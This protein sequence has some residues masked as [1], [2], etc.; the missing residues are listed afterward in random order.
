M[1]NPVVF[2]AGVWVRCEPELSPEADRVGVDSQGSD[3]PVAGDGFS[4]DSFH[5]SSADVSLTVKR[6]DDNVTDVIPTGGGKEADFHPCLRSAK[7]SGAEQ[8]MLHRLDVPTA[9][10][11]GGESEVEHFCLQGT[12]LAWYATSQGLQV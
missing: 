3:V 5:D 7:V 6:F 9:N 10:S 1:P 8:F 2:E 4:F 11:Q 12:F